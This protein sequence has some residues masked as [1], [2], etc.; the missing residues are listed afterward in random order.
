VLGPGRL[1]CCEYLV[2]DGDIIE[3]DVESR[4]RHLAVDDIDLDRRRKSWEPAKTPPGGYARLYHDHV[5]QANLGAG[6]QDIAID[7]FSVS[8]SYLSHAAIFR[9]DCDHAFGITSSESTDVR[10]PDP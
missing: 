10:A 5:M 3:L 1:G 7:A 6:R 2:Q 9:H 8:I 4:K